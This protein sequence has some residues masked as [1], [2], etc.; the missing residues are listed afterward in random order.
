MARDHQPAIAIAEDQVTRLADNPL[1]QLLK[2]SVSLSLANA[3]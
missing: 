1:A 3:G 2:N